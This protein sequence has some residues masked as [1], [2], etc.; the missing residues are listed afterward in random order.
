MSILVIKFDAKQLRR[1]QLMLRDIPKQLPRIMSRALNK[2]ATAA[3]AEIVRKIAGEIKLKQKTIRENIK[4]NR[5]TFR[6]WLAA[7]TISSKK[8]PLI[9][10]GGRQLK[11]GVS[12]QI[13]RTG[14]RKK[15][16]YDPETN[17][18]F[19]AVMKSGHRGIYERR[20][21]GRLPIRELMGPNIQSVFKNAPGLAEKVITETQAKLV[22]NIDA[23]IAYVI[24]K[25]RAAA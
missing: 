3:R 7:I 21:P 16:L 6:H 17:R 8:I 12:Y 18:V 19:I 5:A 14:G 22:H 25:R 9:E 10:F 15:I 1:I 11:S 13:S 23:Q 2:T 4:L 24:A 20:G